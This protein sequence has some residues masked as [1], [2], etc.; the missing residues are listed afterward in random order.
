MTDATVVAIVTALPPTIAAIAALIV[1]IRNGTRSA[2]R[3]AKVDTK[4]NTIIDKTAEI[5]ELTNGNLSRT[6]DALQV[7]TEKVV[8]LEKLVASLT[9]ASTKTPPE[10][11]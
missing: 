2:E 11:P 1:T 7:S 6:A 3:V 5:H 4:V 10:K 8:H 9:E